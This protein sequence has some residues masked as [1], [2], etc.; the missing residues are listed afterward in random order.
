MRFHANVEETKLR[1]LF[2]VN[3]NYFNAWEGGTITVI[4]NR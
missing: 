1:Y 2:Q 3:L 4:V